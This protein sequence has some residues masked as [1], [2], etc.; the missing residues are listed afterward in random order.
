[1]LP[2]NRFQKFF[3]FYGH[4]SNGKSKFIE[5]I[6]DIVGDAGAT[7]PLSRFSEPFAVYDL[8]GKCVSTSTE[9]K[10]DFIECTNTLKAIVSGDMIRAERKFRDSFRFRPYAKIIVAMNEMPRSK[11]VSFGFYRRMELLDWKV[12]FI[13][14]RGSTELNPPYIMQSDLMIAEKLKREHSGIFN[15]ALVGLKRLIETNTF[16]RS[17]AH[18]ALQREFFDTSNLVALFFKL[19]YEDGA[20]IK[21]EVYTKKDIYLQYRTWCEMDGH[22]P[23]SKTWFFRN[24]TSIKAVSHTFRQVVDGKQERCTT[25]FRPQ[26]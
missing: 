9:D 16:T 2:D 8:Y 23:L 10:S 20:L 19:S 13:D 1:M 5:V 4:G 18:I 25:V 15:W 17:K 12:R 6:E 21:G 26:L 14:S 3:V 7:V 24:A 22:Y 11:D